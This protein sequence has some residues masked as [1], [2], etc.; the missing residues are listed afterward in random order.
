MLTGLRKVT[1]PSAVMILTFVAV[2]VSDL[3]AT[4]A[5]RIA[6]VILMSSGYLTDC[7]KFR[8]AGDIALVFGCV[9][10]CN[11]VPFAFVGRISGQADGGKADVLCVSCFRCAT[12]WPALMKQSH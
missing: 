4:M 12:E 11:S 3:S 9:L 7:P 6:A 1:L 10:D 5:R 8:V 2:I